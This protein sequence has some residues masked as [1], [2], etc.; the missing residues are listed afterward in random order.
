MDC[1]ASLGA[2]GV[3]ADYSVGPDC[4]IVSA[5]SRTTPP[6]PVL[7]CRL[8]GTSTG[9]SRAAAISSPTPTPLTGWACLQ[10]SATSRLGG[11]PL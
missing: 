4:C 8:I 3:V 9:A 1:S 11:A 6:C 10:T 2:A 5:L 7:S